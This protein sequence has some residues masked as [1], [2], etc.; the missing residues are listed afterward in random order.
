MQEYEVS[1]VPSVN[2]PAFQNLMPPQ[3]TL[4]RNTHL[5]LVPQIRM[6]KVMSSKV[7][8]RVTRS[9]L[10]IPIH[11]PLRKLFRSQEPGSCALT[12]SDLEKSHF[13]G[14]ELDSCSLNDKPIHF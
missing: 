6:L 2:F 4:G 12:F 5:L 14:Q 11:P 10:Q 7:P 8:K 13:G 3:T 9:S 1:T